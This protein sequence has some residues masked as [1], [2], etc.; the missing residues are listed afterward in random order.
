MSELLPDGLRELLRRVDEVRGL[1]QRNDAGTT[2][3]PSD[4]TALLETLSEL[5]EELEHSHRRL[6]ETNVQ[7]VSLREVASHL[8]ASV[9]AM[10]TT[11]TVTRYLCRA[12]GFGHV[13]LLLVNR[14]AG[15]LEG[16]WAHR[17]GDREHSV[18][19]ELP[20]TGD[21]GALARA[22]WLNRTV[23][24]QS[25]R[26]HSSALL[27]DGHPLQDLL[28]SVQATVS[29]PLVRSHAMLPAR[30]TAELCGER[31]MMGDTFLLAPPPG[32]H[33][34]H[35]ASEREER[36]RQCLACELM[37]MLGVLGVAR[38]PGTP[39]LR[40]SDVTLIESIALSVAPMLENARLTQDLRQSERFLQ[41]V[42]HSMA[43]GLTAVN[44]RGEILALNRAAETLLGCTAADVMGRPF[45]DAF[46]T[47]A[48]AILQSALEHGR[49]AIREETMMRARDGSPVP[50]SFSTSLLRN[51]RRVVYGAIASFVD[52]TPLKRAEEHARQMDRLAALGRFTSSVAH[53]IRNP[54]TGIAAGVQYLSRSIDTSGAQG[55]HLSFLLGEIKRLDRIVQ[56]LFDITHPRQLQLRAAPLEDTVKRA[57]QILQAFIA[58]RGVEVSLEVEPR[59]PVVPHDDDQL[60]QVL[61]NLVKNAVEA[62]SAGA[63]VRVR[64][65]AAQPEVRGT[66]I[67][68]P[69]AVCVQIQD[70]GPG[71]EAEPMRHV[72][73]PFFTT[74]PGGTGLGLYISH[75]I[76]KR[77]SG[78][79]TVQSEPGRGATF[80]V[81][82]PLEPE[83]G[84][85]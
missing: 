58:E 37:P 44:M 59:V 3:D 18:D 67:V 4:T 53:E 30:D 1:S 6:I 10:E 20:L 85:P 35:W 15:R 24:H 73:E 82:L 57:L 29:V 32:P 49:E 55:E 22:F 68:V 51:E 72:F 7:L 5:V 80:T 13:A 54:L 65:T 34:E 38:E 84:L 52:L 28:A 78:A 21:G 26:R 76:V 14:E 40:N 79:L 2:L 39:A 81:R 83:G 25:P 19:F 9:D 69:G 48:E 66:R 60:E 46:G 56:D 42:L 47:D 70:Q 23:V 63:R 17:I 50:V 74:K 77:H 27:P 45:G 36:Q 75:D 16:T 8:P 33:A 62:S 12:F 64:I 31:C 61:I 71:I 43:S 41:H 11:R